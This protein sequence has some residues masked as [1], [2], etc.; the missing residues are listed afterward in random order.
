MIN[1]FFD[2][3]ARCLAS[4]ILLGCGSSAFAGAQ[5]YEFQAVHTEIKQG[6]GSTVSVRLI[7]KRTGNAVPDAVIFATRMDMTPDGMET[8]TTTVEPSASVEP[9]VYTFTTNLSME[10]GWRFQLAAKVQGEAET[11]TGELILKAVP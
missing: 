8:M 2:A 6:A 7:D 3:R 5:D 10:G 9:G 4:A 11:V 1:I